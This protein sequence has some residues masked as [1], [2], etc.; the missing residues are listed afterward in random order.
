MAVAPA[1]MSRAAFDTQRSTTQRH[2]SLS[3]RL[4]RQVSSLTLRAL[5]TDT[6]LLPSCGCVR[7]KKQTIR[8]VTSNPQIWHV[9]KPAVYPTSKSSYAF[10]DPYLIPLPGQLAL[11]PDDSKDC[12]RLVERLGRP[13]RIDR[14]HRACGELRKTGGLVSFPI[15]SD[16]RS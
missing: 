9:Q 13:N 8:C 2:S 6:A 4:T 16:I 3:R 12:F 5:C 1:C 14:G 15:F 11:P 10:L 7:T